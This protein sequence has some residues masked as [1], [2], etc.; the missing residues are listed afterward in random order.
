MVEIMNQRLAPGYRTTF[1]SVTVSATSGGASGDV[2]FTVPQNHDLEMEYLG[3]SNG[4]ASNQKITVEVFH[5]EDSTY[6]Y[7]TQAHQV[8]GHDTYHLINADR[9]H[10][11]AGD[12]IIVS[13]DGGTFA[14]SLSGKL[15]YNP[16]RT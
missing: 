4:G 1:E 16:N 5:A 6:H 12:K 3:A 9:I 11:H 8:T 7:L 14:V 10:L 13:K 15:Y 2:L